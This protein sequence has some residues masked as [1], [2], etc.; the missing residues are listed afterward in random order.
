MHKRAFFLQK[1]I[2]NRPNKLMLIY[3][4]ICII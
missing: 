3:A 4:D 2:F 1:K